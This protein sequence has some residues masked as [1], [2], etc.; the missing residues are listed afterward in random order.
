MQTV[1]DYLI[2]GSGAG[3]SAAAY[4]LTRAGASVLL[5]ERGH[6]LPRDG[7]TLD[8]GKV[9]RDGVFRSQESFHDRSGQVIFPGEYANLGG[10]TKWY[11]A[12]LLRFAPHEFAADA[13]HQCPAWPI[14]YADIEPYYAEAEA[15]LG[16]RTFPIESDL[17]RIVGRFRANGHAWRDQALPVGLAPEIL[18]HPNEAKHF[19]GFA[20]AAGLKSDGERLLERVRDSANLT[21]QTGKPVAALLPS[22][23]NPRRLD[24]V[25][26]ADGKT[27]RARNVLLAGG[28]LHSPRLLQTYLEASSLATVLPAYA[29]VGRNYKYHVLTAMLAL[30][31]RHVTDVLRKTALLLADEFPHSSV[32]NTGYVD[33]EILATEAPAFTP[34][35]LSNAL[36]RR[37][38][39]FWLTTEDGSHPENRVIAA[40]GSGRPTLD[41]DVRR[42]RPAQDEHR[43]LVRAVR[44]GLI[45]AGYL[46][47]SKPI[48]IV[49]SAHACGTLMAGDDP[50]RSVVGPDGR[51][52]GLE[53]I[54]AVDGSVLTRS[55]RA[56]PALTIYAWSLRV[57]DRLARTAAA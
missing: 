24:G 20:S 33:G 36:G 21:I 8:V 32:Q 28:A 55:S 31:P 43:R 15:L 5:L 1:Y 46:P 50:A 51:V 25:V 49:G 23:R 40:N 17:S 48:P 9:L 19:D 52:H 54:Y 26:C 47:I 42:L 53:N 22:A 34:R 38:Y 14:A 37:A 57:A 16:V 29:N 18:A 35:W 3:G 10:K 39:G 11:G 13:A 44:N 45:A 12:A 2:V 30:S 27:Y 41:Y 4:R 6:R 7:S 56:N